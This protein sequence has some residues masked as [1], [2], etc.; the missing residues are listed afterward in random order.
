VISVTLDT[1]D[2]PDGTYTSSFTINSNAQN[3]P[4]LIVPLS[5][6]VETPEDPFPI[7]PRFV[8][9]WEP[10]TGAI[11]RYP[12]GQPYSL[13]RD[14]SQDALL[15]VI[16]TSANQ[17]TAN[18]SLQSNGVTMANV[19]YINAASDSYWVRDYG[20]WT[21]FD[22]DH[23]MHL[24]DFA[25]NRPRPNDDIIP[26]TVADYLGKEIYDL[27]INHTG[28][29]IMTDGMG[30]AM[31]TELVLSENISLSQTQ[32]NQRF[33]DFLGVSEYQI[34]TDPTNTYIDHIDCWAKLLDVDKV[35]IRRVPTGHPHTP[36]SKHLLPMAG[37]DQLLRYSVSHLPG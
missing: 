27:N 30:K 34:Y 4:A 37:K 10:A 29:N 12:F 20:A 11:V 25:Y 16:V 8:A 36:P 21:I 31:S 3:N 5:L 2:L 9:E 24:V 32:I 7:E 19:R 22:A 28:G 1:N 15:Y 35:I 23:N 33:S 17:S 18:S 26:I 14:L 13:L 6:T